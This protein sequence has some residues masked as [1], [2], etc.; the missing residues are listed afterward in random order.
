M[1]R[2]TWIGVAVIVVILV[3]VTA[4]FSLVGP[5]SVAIIDGYEF[6]F[7]KKKISSP[8]AEYFIGPQYGSGGSW[9]CLSGVFQPVHAV[10]RW[11]RPDKWHRLQR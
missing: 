2:L 1:I 11:L 7:S 4:Y 5:G 6:D 10:D 9:D 3:Y 8:Y